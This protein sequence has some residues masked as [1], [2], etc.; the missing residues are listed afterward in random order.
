VNDY[1]TSAV[2][3]EWPDAEDNVGVTGYRI[4]LDDELVES[5]DADENQVILTDLDEGTEYTFYVKARDAE[6]NYSTRLS[7]TFTTED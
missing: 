6:G 4:Y 3:L 2:K 7:E 5:V 1:S